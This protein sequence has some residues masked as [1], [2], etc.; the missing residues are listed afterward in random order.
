VTFN[1]YWILGLVA[2]KGFVNE[3]DSLLGPTLSAAHPTLLL[4]R[5]PIRSV[6]LPQPLVHKGFIS[7]R[8]RVNADFY[9]I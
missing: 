3:K 7:Q 6:W 2:L 8:Q 5:E 9:S 1:R 4:R